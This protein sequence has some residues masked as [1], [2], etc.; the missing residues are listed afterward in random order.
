MAVIRDEKE[1]DRLLWAAR[2]GMLELDLV[3][4]PYAKSCY[5]DS[6]EEDK[7]AFWALLDCQDPD[8]FQWFIKSAEPAPEHRDIV[9]KILHFK[10][11]SH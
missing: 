5:M 8:L 2:R 3:L 4:E 1:L 6:S 9:R 11:N 10:R 7:Q